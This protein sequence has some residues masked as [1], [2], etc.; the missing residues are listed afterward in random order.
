LNN[1]QSKYI[2]NKKMILLEK[3]IKR[4]MTGTSYTYL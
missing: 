4:T 3:S 1:I 2:S